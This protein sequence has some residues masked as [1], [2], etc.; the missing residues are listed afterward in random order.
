MAPESEESVGYV[1]TSAFTLKFT[2]VIFHQLNYFY[3]V[4]FGKTF[5][6]WSTW[7]LIWNNL[8]LVFP[9]DWTFSR[10]ANIE[11]T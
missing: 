5:Y 3:W 7:L 9:T 10:Q 11:I 1:K 6:I 8:N 2:N 4:L